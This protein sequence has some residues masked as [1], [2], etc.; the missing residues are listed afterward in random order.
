M[1]AFPWMT[2][3]CDESAPRGLR[4]FGVGGGGGGGGL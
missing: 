2:L 1:A 3:L 4:R